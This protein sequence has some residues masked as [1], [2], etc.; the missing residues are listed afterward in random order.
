[1]V[2]LRIHNHSRRE[3]IRK[4]VM[5]EGI[6]LEGADDAVEDDPF[7]GIDSDAFHAAVATHKDKELQALIDA[8]EAR[9]DSEHK[10]EALQMLQ[11]SQN[12]KML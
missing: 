3:I 9:A 12:S 1:M 10:A 8:I 5:E 7:A 4:Q 6:H 2:Q 11:A